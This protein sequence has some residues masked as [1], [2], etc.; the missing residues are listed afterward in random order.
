[1]FRK[2]HVRT[3]AA[4]GS[5]KNTISHMLIFIFVIHKMQNSFKKSQ[6]ARRFTDLLFTQFLYGLALTTPRR[7]DWNG[8]R[9]N[10]RTQW[11]RNSIRGIFSA[12]S[13]WLV[14]T[15]RSWS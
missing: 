6:W 13:D 8:S 9:S 15:L 4:G 2:C 1:M 10:C 7:I 14:A 11:V 5:S 12:G 3:D